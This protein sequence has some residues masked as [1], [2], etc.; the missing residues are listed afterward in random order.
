MQFGLLCVESRIFTTNRCPLIITEAFMIDNSDP[1][2]CPGRADD[3]RRGGNTRDKQRK[4]DKNASERVTETG[5]KGNISCAP[6]M[7]LFR[8]RS[9][10]PTP[11]GIQPFSSKK[12]GRNRT[13][14]I[15]AKGS[16]QTDARD[17]REERGPGKRPPLPRLPWNGRGFIR[18]PSNAH[19]Y[20]IRKQTYVKTDV[21]VPRVEWP[22]RC[23]ILGDNFQFLGEEENVPS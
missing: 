7:Y 9:E 11:D 12:E 10:Y 2:L 5:T 18:G 3:W 14:I 19:L 4:R 20:Q 8:A 16:F 21:G 15:R 1:F 13:D 23:L 22:V 6:V 17:R